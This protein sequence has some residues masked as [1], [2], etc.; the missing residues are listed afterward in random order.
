[1]DGFNPNAFLAKK[2][3]TE[4]ILNDEEEMRDKIKAKS[5]LKTANNT[6]RKEKNTEENKTETSPET[7]EEKPKV[8]Q[9]KRSSD[10]SE[11]SDTQVIINKEYKG[12]KRKSENSLKPEEPIVK[13]RKASPIVFDV[14]TKEDGAKKRERERTEDASSDNHVVVTTTSNTHK[15][16]SLPPREY[17]TFLEIIIHHTYY[18]LIHEN[19]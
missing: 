13:K 3:M 19:M 15:Y 9:K 16:D 17:T 2:L 1:M 7:T 4:G 8:A 12:D 14:G 18:K 5:V 11:D 10:T 6:E